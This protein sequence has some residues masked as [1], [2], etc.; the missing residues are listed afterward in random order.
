MQVLAAT[1]ANLEIALRVLVVDVPAMLCEQSQCAPAFIVLD[2]P[3]TF[4]PVSLASGRA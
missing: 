3:T 4:V 1:A 2:H